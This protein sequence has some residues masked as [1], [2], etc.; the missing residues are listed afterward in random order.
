MKPSEEPKKNVIEPELT[1]LLPDPFKN[2]FIVTPAKPVI[3]K[4]NVK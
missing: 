4:G 1:P 3:E 2:L